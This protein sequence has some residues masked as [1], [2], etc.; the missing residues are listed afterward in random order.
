MKI[1][2]TKLEKLI[3]QTTKGTNFALY[4]HFKILKDFI[5]YTQKNKTFNPQE[6][7]EALIQLKELIEIA[8]TKHPAEIKNSDNLLQETDNIIGKINDY[9]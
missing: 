5:N 4:I 7:I 9:I 6:I 3:K 1:E 2:L 8:K